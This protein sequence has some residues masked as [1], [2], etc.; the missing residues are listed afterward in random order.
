MTDFLL[1]DDGEMRIENGDFVI[2]D[3]ESQDVELL[4]TSSKGAWKEHPLTGVGIAQLIKTRATEVRIK[5]DINEQL[6]LDGFKNIDIDI[7]YPDLNV[8]ANR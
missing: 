1:S 6:M 4:I 8:D 3:S 5:R 7:D 2:G